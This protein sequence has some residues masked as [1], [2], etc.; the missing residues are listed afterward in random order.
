MA[1]ID[2]EDE[3][4]EIRLGKERNPKEIIRDMA[5]I[6]AM[7]KLKIGEETK[8]GFVLR[9]GRDDYATSMATTGNNVGKRESREATAK[10]LVQEMYREWQIRG[11]KPSK[12]R[13]D[14]LN[15]KAETVLSSRQSN[16]RSKYCYNCGSKYHRRNDF[17]LF[18]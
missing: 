15:R 17:P 14:E 6:E 13:D 7:Y 12:S 1:E 2:M 11:G 3:L 16:K 8:A 10:E 4:R 9:I 5:A 18:R